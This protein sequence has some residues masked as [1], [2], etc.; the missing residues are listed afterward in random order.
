MQHILLIGYTNVYVN[1]PPLSCNSEKCVKYGVLYRSP[2]SMAH[3]A[4]CPYRASEETRAKF[5]RYNLKEEITQRPANDT[6]AGGLVMVA[7]IKSQL[8]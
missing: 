7:S 5:L 8:L 6:S 1:F 3:V 2:F 4:S